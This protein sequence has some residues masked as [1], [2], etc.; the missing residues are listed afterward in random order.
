MEIKLKEGRN[1]SF[2]NQSDF[3]NRYQTYIVN[4]E[5]GFVD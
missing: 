2:D 4:E 3:A 1:L 5:V